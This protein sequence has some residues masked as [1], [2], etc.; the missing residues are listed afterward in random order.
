MW[1]AARRRTITSEVIE[2]CPGTAHNAAM[3]SSSPA[4]SA[5][6]DL[7]Q[8]GFGTLLRQWRLLRS[9]SQLELALRTD[10]SQRHLSF[11]ESG[12]SRPSRDMVLAL[13]N[14]LDIPLRE[15][16]SL[17]AAA[18][19]APVYDQRPLLEPDMVPVLQALQL[20]LAHHEPYP[21][22]VA[23]QAWNLLMENRAA[24]ALYGLLGDPEDFWRRTCGDGPRN[25]MRALFHPQ[26]MRPYVL[27]WEQVGRNLLNRLRHEAALQAPDS[28]LRRLLHDILQFPGTPPQWRI[29]DGQLLV[30]PVL[31]IE[32]GLGDIR[33]RLFSMIAHFGTPQD[34]TV[35][36]LVL[37]TFF[38]ADAATEA[39]LRQLANVPS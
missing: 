12:R 23:D 6:A 19:F 11:L 29:A 38:P 34:V 21:A 26:G 20:T 10:I 37:E 36:E 3:I 39:L 2:C 14:V 1:A 35:D 22:I 27:N 31:C 30:E 15:R 32:L 5:R 25:V 8:N 4:S 17:L 18:G 24:Q 16:N 33:I 9:L 7:S 13:G 28:S